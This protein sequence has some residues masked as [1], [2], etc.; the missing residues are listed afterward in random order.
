M[1]TGGEAAE[2]VVRMSLEGFEVAA[3]I[4]GEGAKAIAILLYS[5]LREEQK[6]KGKARLTNM[7]RSGKELKVFTIRNCDLRKFN[8]EAKKY[9]VLYCV[10]ADRKNK[11]PMAAVDVIAR[12]EDAAKISRIVERFNLATVE[13]A[14]VTQ[15]EKDGQAGPEQEEKEQLL[16]ALLG[17]PEEKAEPKTDGQEQEETEQL[18]DSL[19]DTPEMDTPEE[20]AEPETDGQEQ[21]ETEQT[22]DAI[23]KKP[24]EKEVRGENP[25]EAKTEN[26]PRSAPTSEKLQN[27]AD[28]APLMEKSEKPS[29]REMLRQIIQSR[30]EQ[31]KEQESE[32]APS[33]EKSAEKSKS[34][35]KAKS[36]ERQKKK[37][38][39]K[40]KESK[41]ER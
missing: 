19:L 22:G 24:E 34:A 41:G 11:N 39:K 27:S 10:L 9:G 17:A 12:A 35:T 29:I 23:A 33:K 16:N 20:K 1:S 26:D 36:Q 14:T 40:V 3:K 13:T 18:V 28:G 7:L 15:T 31:E 21:E 2:Q 6:T 30:K 38:R 37:K 4:A 25:S 8:E 5:I 32:P